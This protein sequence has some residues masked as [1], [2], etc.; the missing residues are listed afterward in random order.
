MSVRTAIVT[1]S[2]GLPTSSGWLLESGLLKMFL[3]EDPGDFDASRVSR[4]DQICVRKER[5]Y[6]IGPRLD[7]DEL[8]PLRAALLRHCL[9]ASARR[10]S[11]DFPEHNADVHE[12]NPLLLHEQSQKLNKQLSQNNTRV[13]IVPLTSLS[14]FNARSEYAASTSI[15]T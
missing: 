11:V 5:R 6:Y 15:T 12:T 9:S 13:R 3:S 8:D 4:C 1:S 10:V 7:V 14:F 2:S